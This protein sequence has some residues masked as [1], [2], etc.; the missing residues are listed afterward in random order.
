M[1]DEE[2]K[3]EP[4]PVPA[5][6]EVGHARSTA[7]L[8]PRLYTQPTAPCCRPP[9]APCASPSFALCSISMRHA[10]TRWPPRE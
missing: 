6:A 2:K 8:R 3:E 10:V 5:P 1:A 4:A 7:A 9:L